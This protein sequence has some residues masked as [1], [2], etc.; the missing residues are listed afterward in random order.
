MRKRSWL[1]A[2][3]MLMALALVT[4]ACGTDDEVAETTQA[5]TTAAAP[6][7]TPAEEPAEEPAEQPADEPEPEDMGWE[8]SGDV[9]WIVPYNPGGGFDTYSRGLAQVLSEGG[10]LPDGV[11]VVVENITP[12]QQGVA[13]MFT[14]DADGHTMGILPM[15]AAIAQ[16]LINPEI[17]PWSTGEFTVLGSIEENAYVLYVAADGPYQSIDDL[18]G[19]SGLQSLTVER[20]SSSSIANVVATG[21]LGLDASI[22]FGA[23]G[24]EEAATAL[25][26]GDVDYIVYGTTDLV[27]FMDS[28]DLRALLFL[29]TE[30]QRPAALTWLADVP[31]IADVGY[32]EAAG[33]V[34]ELRAVVM[35]PGL[36]DE[37]AEYWRN[38]LFEAMNSDDFAA[39]SEEAGRPI[40]PRNA[41][42]A[43]GVMA[44]QVDTM[45]ALDP[46]LVAQLRSEGAAAAP[47][48]EPSGDVTWIVPY[49]PGGG[50]DT[51]SRGLAQVLSEGGF[52]PDGVTVVVENITPIQQGVAAMFTGDADG[53]TMG[54]LPMPAAIAQELINPE[55][56]PWS[57]GEFTVLGSIEE[58]AYVLYVAADGP[59]QSIDDLMGA[60]GLQSLTVERGSSSSI[61]NVVATGA[62][63]LD[64][65]INF[66]AEGSE[67]AATALIRGDVDYI[68]YGTTDLV[69]FMD[70]GDLR[71]LLFLGTEDQ[72]P[73]AL[74]WLADVPSI[75]DVGYPEAAGSVTE[76][77]AV[78]MPP[79]LD[80]EVAEYWKRTL[81]T[82]MMSDDFAAW[83]EEAGRPII[84]RGAESAKNVMAAQVETMKALDPDLVAQLR[85]E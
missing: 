47:S 23:E 9:T 30:D 36:D 37:V 43:R 15:P 55:I 12:I 6:E 5:P 71:A 14:G 32:P 84:P 79:G 69:G 83:S 7:E 20:G 61:A 75:A 39:W 40:I 74:T 57:T 27:G 81:I 78:V 66:G 46:D 10:F 41:E 58:N 42:S 48:W 60:S 13:A 68:V 19:A 24:S 50:F 25:I 56:S 59:Y 28:G 65:S 33:S 72:R 2:L 85:S 76:L 45:R 8:P 51:Y 63:G 53:H 26:R 67:E 54:I 70:S 44:A 62:L 77:R 31:S 3:V 49:N 22:N 18:M 34:T 80:D 35:P 29:G 16:E 52:L 64:A 73:A 38:T 82:A 1:S 11:T 17:S 4:A 21:A